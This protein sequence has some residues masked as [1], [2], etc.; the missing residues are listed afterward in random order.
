MKT[1]F[2]Q[3]KNLRVVWDTNGRTNLTTMKFP[4]LAVVPYV[5]VEWLGKMGRTPNE[6]R[7]WLEYI[8]KI[9]INCQREDWA[10]FFASAM[11]AA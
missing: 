5:V 7:V 3:E 6:L 11:A 9:Y 2:S 4:R 10:L 8:M 1:H